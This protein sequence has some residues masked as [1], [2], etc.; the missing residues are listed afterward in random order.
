MKI[1]LLV[2][3]LLLLPVAASSQNIVP[4]EVVQFENV[5]VDDDVKTVAV[6]NA[7]RHYSL[8]CN[9]KAAGCITP[10][11]NKNY[12]L[13]NK[14]TR[15]KMPGAAGRGSDELMDYVENFTRATVAI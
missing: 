8:F 3:L 11:P 7:N 2:F 12:L 10:E 9:V 4:P 1:A 15:W 6:G 5:H 14:N 13:F